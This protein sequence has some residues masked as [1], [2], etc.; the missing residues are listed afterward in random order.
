MPTNGL[1]NKT[2]LFSRRQD[3]QPVTG[4]QCVDRHQPLDER[5]DGPGV[6]LS[7]CA[8]CLSPWHPLILPVK[9]SYSVVTRI[10]TPWTPRNAF[11]AEHGSQV[12]PTR[13]RPSV[14]Q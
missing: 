6:R 8:S 7:K 1:V 11:Q 3:A 13:L 2:E 14:L 5:D 9:S 4:K 12:V 10:A